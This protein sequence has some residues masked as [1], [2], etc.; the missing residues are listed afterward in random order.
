MKLSLVLMVLLVSIGSVVALTAAKKNKK[1][2]E[3]RME[4]VGRGTWSRP[5]PPAGRSSLRP[6]STS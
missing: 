3:V 4:E 2:V 5:S 6:R 1:A